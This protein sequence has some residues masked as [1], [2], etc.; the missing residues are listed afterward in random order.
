VVDSRDLL[1]NLQLSSLHNVPQWHYYD[2]TILTNCH[3]RRGRRVVRSAYQGHMM[4]RSRGTWTAQMMHRLEAEGISICQS[5]SGML[6]AYLR[7]EISGKDLL[8]HVC[9]FKDLSSYQQWLQQCFGPTA[10]SIHSS[11]SI[12]LLMREVEYGFRRKYCGANPRG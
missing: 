4:H 12:E 5:D 3:S 7:N 8:A 10:T 2:H 6:G 9:Q 11:V 1:A